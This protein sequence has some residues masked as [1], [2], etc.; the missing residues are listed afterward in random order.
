MIK[1]NATF[2]LT[3]LNFI[4]LVAILSSILWKPMLKFLDERTKKISDSLKLAEENEKREQEIKIEHGEIVNKARIK[5]AEIVDKAMTDASNESRELIAQAREHAHLT[6]DSAKQEIKMEAE[7][8]KQDLRKEIS[9]LTVSL[10]S[11]V[12]EREIKDKDH[13]ELN[14]KG[15]DVLGS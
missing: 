5:A 11:K 14:K 10:A 12:L 9:D 1:I 3:V 7:R 6:V 15:L 2:I 4:L 8:I 13:R